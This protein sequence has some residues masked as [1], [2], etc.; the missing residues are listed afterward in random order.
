MSNPMCSWNSQQR[1]LILKFH[2]TAQQCTRKHKD[3]WIKKS[4]LVLLSVRN[5]RRFRKLAISVAE[6]LVD[7]WGTHGPLWESLVEQTGF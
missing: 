5:N 7:P 4:F 6:S 1:K 2:V 3:A